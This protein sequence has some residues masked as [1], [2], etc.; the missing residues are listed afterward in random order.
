MDRY[1]LTL[2][3]RL[4]DGGIKGEFANQ[5]DL[6]LGAVGFDGRSVR[7]VDVGLVDA[8]QGRDAKVGRHSQCAVQVG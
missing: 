1:R 3:H 8:D 2:D 4:G 7:G 6:V 5:L